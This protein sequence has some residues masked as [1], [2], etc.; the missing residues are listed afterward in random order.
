MGAAKRRHVMDGFLGGYFHLIL[1]PRT[2]GLEIRIVA[3]LHFLR[4][5]FLTTAHHHTNIITT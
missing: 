5:P 4:S 3:A 1:T 2:L